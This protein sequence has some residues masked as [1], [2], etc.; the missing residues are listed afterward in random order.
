M[1]V[2]I[3][4]RASVAA[5]IASGFDREGVPCTVV[6]S[7]LAF[8]WLV[9]LSEADRLVIDGIVISSDALS[10]QRIKEFRA[11]S[12]LAMVAVV[13]R[14]SLDETLG[15]FTSGIDDVVSKPVHPL[16]L[17]AR[18]RVASRRIRSK[19]PSFCSSDVVVFLD[20]RDPLVGGL[21]LLLPR[22]ERR[23]LAC[24]AAARGGWVTKGHL[25]SQVYGLF[26]DG[27]HEAVIESH[28][29]RLRKRLR[30][31]LSYDPIETQRFLGYR[32]REERSRGSA[33]AP[34]AS[35]GQVA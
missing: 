15:L 9:S 21:P 6:T 19:T 5:A 22:R 3:E 34:T 10:G 29:S 31:R 13:D 27:I 23:I 18:L 28:V 1:I 8:D 32:L 20:G 24:L 11:Q 35:P 25:F 12:D 14:R 26:N 30:E 4:N 7:D 16:E 33:F 17:I 2:L